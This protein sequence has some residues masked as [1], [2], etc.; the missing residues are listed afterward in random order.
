MSQTPNQALLNSGL[1][2]TPTIHNDTYPFMDPTNPKAGAVP[3]GRSIFI[4]GA[5][6]GIERARPR[7]RT[8][9]RAGFTKIGIGAGSPLASL[10][11][12]IAAAASSISSAFA[13]KLDVLVANAGYLEAWLPASEIDLDDWWR[14]YEVN[15]LGTFLTHRFFAPLV[16]ASELRTVLVVSSIASHVLAVGGM[17]YSGAK[18]ALLRFAERIM[19]EEEE[20]GTGLLACSVHPGGVQ[21][22]LTSAVAEEMGK[23]VLVDKVEL[24]ADS[25]VWLTRERREW[26]A[27]RFVSCTWDMQELEQKREKIEKGDLRKVRM[28]VELGN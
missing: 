5:S 22:E 20:K 18:L 25:M 12:E 6:K 27:R 9:A 10:A 13:G 14:S 15:V 24:A 19:L 3:A 11:A 23:R 2:F 26:L 1:N 28:A 4:I 16:R 7:C 17:A 21:T 8:Y